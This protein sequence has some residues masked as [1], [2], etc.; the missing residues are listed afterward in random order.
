MTS[1]LISTPKKVRRL[2]SGHI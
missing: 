1:K 2:F